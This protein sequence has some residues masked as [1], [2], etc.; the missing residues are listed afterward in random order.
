MPDCSWIKKEGSTI[1]TRTFDYELKNETLISPVKIWFD[2][3]NDWD[4][5]RIVLK[6][7]CD[8]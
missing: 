8:F 2:V 4:A 6:D 3:K 5:M 1:F 7:V